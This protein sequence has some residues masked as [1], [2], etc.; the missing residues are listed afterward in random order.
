[1]NAK[2]RDLLNIIRSKGSLDE[3]IKSNGENRGGAVNF[4]TI[5]TE[6]LGLCDKSYTKRISY[7]I[8]K[9]NIAKEDYC[10]ESVDKFQ[11]YFFYLA[12]A[13]D[14][15]RAIAGGELVYGHGFNDYTGAVNIDGKSI[16]SYRKWCGMLERCYSEKWHKKKPSYKDCEVSKE[17]QIFSNFKKWFDENNIEGYFL[18]KDILIKGNK[19]YSKETCLFVPEY[20]NS[21]FIAR[22]NDRGEY[23]VGVTYSK[24]NKCFIARV[25]LHGVRKTFGRFSNAEDAFAA[26]KKGKEDYIQTVAKEYLDKALISVQIYNALMTYEISEN[27]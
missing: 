2:K 23:P 5:L 20:I 26:Y 16:P 10:V 19:T 3:F 1:M 15:L 18:D 4:R 11:N 17:W 12:P 8:K 24:T 22:T 14:L 25:S 6:V 9:L 27:D 13:S 21:L 7:Y